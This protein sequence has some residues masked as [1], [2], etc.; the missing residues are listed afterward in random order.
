M[1]PRGGRGE[2]RMSQCFN[3]V[4]N[5]ICERIELREAR[6]TKFRL[7]YLVIAILVEFYRDCLLYKLVSSE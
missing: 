2:Y 3:I 6:I 1:L 5:I 7:D 4:T